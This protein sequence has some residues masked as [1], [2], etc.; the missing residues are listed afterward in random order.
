MYAK[1]P[2]PKELA[3]FGLK[4]SDIDTEDVIVWPENHQVTKVFLAMKTQWRVGMAGYTGLDYSA[5]PEVWRRL[6]VSPAD[7]DAVFEDLR[8]IEQ[9]A[10]LTM[11]ADGKK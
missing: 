3:A 1:P 6:K 9:A 10:L 11:H 2:D 7:R 4:P 8:L 5:L